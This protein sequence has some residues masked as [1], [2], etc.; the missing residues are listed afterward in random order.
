[1]NLHKGFKMFTEVYRGSMKPEWL[2]FHYRIFKPLLPIRMRLQKI[3]QVALLGAQPPTGKK[4][5]VR[6]DHEEATRKYQVFAKKNEVVRK[7]IRKY[8]ARYWAVNQI[9]D[10]NLEEEN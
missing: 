4:L 7:H 9:E 3:T 8:R 10:P 6:C 5:M 1:M 2:D